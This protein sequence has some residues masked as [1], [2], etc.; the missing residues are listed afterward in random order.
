MIYFKKP[1]KDEL[2]VVNFANEYEITF[3]LINSR[4]KLINSDSN[5]EY[6]IESN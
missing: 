2:K 1:S 6:C 3:S 4:P 5:I